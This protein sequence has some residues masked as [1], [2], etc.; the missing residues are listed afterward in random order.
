MLS[1]E[2]RGAGGG[3]VTG[4]QFLLTANDGGK[5]L[6]DCGMVQSSK[7]AKADYF[8]QEEG[9]TDVLIT[10]AHID[11]VG[12]SQLLENPQIRFHM[13]PETLAISD[14]SLK[15][16]EQINP[17]VFP[18]KSRFN[19]LKRVKTH[20]YD[21]EFKIGNGHAVLRNA[22]HILGSA[23]VEIHQDNEIAVFSGDLG[24]S[25]SR[26]VKPTEYIKEADL[27][28]LEAT[29]GD[30]DHGEKD[31]I[32]VFRE[33]IQII[34]E[35]KS[36][37]IIPSFAIDRSQAVLKEFAKLSKEGVINKIPVFM[38]G[39]MASDTTKIYQ[40]SRYLLNEEL[41]NLQKPFHF[42]ELR[43]TYKYSDSLTIDRIRGPKIIVAGSGMMTGGRIV[44]H[45]QKYLEDDKNVIMFVGYTAEDTPSRAI[46][47]GKKVV[48]LDKT[49]VNVNAQVLR[50]SLSAHADQSGLLQWVDHL[51]SPIRPVRKIVLVHGEDIQRQILANKIENRFKINTS[52]PN[53]GEIISFN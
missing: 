40:R 12:L 21:Q 11:H 41:V 2:V 4:S 17:D 20:P 39:P 42:K 16:S 13:T 25:P 50:T 31:P 3:E 49:P 8:P 27:V 7:N 29:Y 10:H 28:V 35:N 43:E 36:T 44:R 38:D 1:L 34:K 32:E 46:F 37:L 15:N 22:G 19:F 30:K 24:D 53:H 48:E 33:G 45:A 51:D 52:I 14:I 5:V 6:V 47:D 23:S 26:T 18:P 9:L